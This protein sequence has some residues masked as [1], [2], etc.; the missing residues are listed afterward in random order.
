MVRPV[1]ALVSLA[2][3]SAAGASHA[4]R[5]DSGHWDGGFDKTAQ[6]RSDFTIGA[7]AGFG[8]GTGLGYPNEVGQI[9][10]PAYETSTGVGSNGGG[11]VW[12]GGALRDW[13][14]FGLGV[15]YASITSGDAK[16]SGGGFVFRLEAFPLFSQGGGLQDL[17]LAG[18][19][20]IGTATIDKG[21]Q[22]R[23]D[24][25]SLSIVG[26]SAFHETWRLG[27]LTLGPMVEYTHTFSQTLSSHGAIAG[28]RI[29]FYSGPSGGPRP[30]AAR[31]RNTTAYDH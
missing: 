19:F 13:F 29:A 7:S 17:G 16:L 22:E 14:T 2:L 15:T 21:G 25:G 12:F 27:R 20:G 28:V 23:A 24:G 26:L 31:L 3:L 18:N 9:D 8:L 5:K 6:R 4:Q 11:T 10:N 1:A 30:S